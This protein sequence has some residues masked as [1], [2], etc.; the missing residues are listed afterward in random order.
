MIRRSLSAPSWRARRCHPGRH[1][2][3]SSPPPTPSPPQNAVAARP[4]RLGSSLRSR[5]WRRRLLFVT[6]LV[7]VLTW[8]APIV[9]ALTPLRHTLARLA[10]PS[11]RGSVTVGSASAGWFRPL[12][13]ND[14]EVHGDD[15]R[16]LLK[17]DAVASKRP[18]IGLA[19]DPARPGLLR[20]VGPELHVV[21]DQ[22]STN[23]ERAFAAYPVPA[24]AEGN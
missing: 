13:L 23:L 18:L 11:L 24:P 12:V 1:S 3:T 2:M 20:L 19:L 22:E 10:L 7:L 21:C 5:A 8:V 17:V 9:V 4:R 16:L 15:G 14:V 6:L